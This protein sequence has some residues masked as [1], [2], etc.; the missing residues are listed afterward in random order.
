MANHMLIGFSGTALASHVMLLCSSTP[1]FSNTVCFRWDRSRPATVDNLV[2][3]T[4]SEAEAHENSDL[5]AVRTG[6]PAF[7]ARV[8][9]ALARARAEFAM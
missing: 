4:F 8:A 7:A 3:L 9:A 2:L 6:D 1:C 5:A